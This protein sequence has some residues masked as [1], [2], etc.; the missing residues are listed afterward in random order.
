[1]GFSSTDVYRFFSDNFFIVT[2]ASGGTSFSVTVECKKEF[3][4]SGEVLPFVDF[5]DEGPP[6]ARTIKASNGKIIGKLP[7]GGVS[8]IESGVP[9]EDPVSIFFEANK[10]VAGQ[11]TKRI[12]GKLP[13]GINTPTFKPGTDINFTDV[14][15]MTPWE[16]GPLFTQKTWLVTEPEP[17]APVQ[18][19]NQRKGFILRSAVFRLGNI[20]P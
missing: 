2:P 15:D 11:P 7:F 4:P 8:A 16:R 3:L 20:T 12:R 14:L 1:M 13:I 10:Q 19:V 6:H 17:L 5:Y 9:H 18:G